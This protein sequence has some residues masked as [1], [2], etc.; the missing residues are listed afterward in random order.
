MICLTHSCKMSVLTCLKRMRSSTW[1]ECGDKCSQGADVMI[2][3]GHIETKAS[4]PKRFVRTPSEA[5]EGWQGAGVVVTGA[6]RRS[7]I[8]RDVKAVRRAKR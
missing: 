7:V 1:P 8:D 3:H 4:K 2:G 5:R 6:R